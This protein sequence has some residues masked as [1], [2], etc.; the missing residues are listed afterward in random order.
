[1]LLMPMLVVQRAFGEGLERHVKNVSM[2]LSEGLKD[3]ACDTTEARG[4]EK[5]R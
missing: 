1:M 3:V 2:S 4:R 5:L